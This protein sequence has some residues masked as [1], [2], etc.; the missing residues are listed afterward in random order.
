[1][2]RYRRRRWLW[3]AAI[4]LVVV[5]GVAAGGYLWIT[6]DP[7]EPVDVDDVVA[8][9]RASTTAAS[10]PAPVTAR[11]T[12]MASAPATTASAPAPTDVSTRPTSSAPVERSDP[13]PGVYV[14]DTTG[15]ESVDALGGSAHEYPAETTITLRQQGGEGCVRARWEALRQRWDEELRCP[16]PDG[17]SLDAKT[18]YH[19]FFRQSEKR[20]F[21]CEPDEVYLPADPAPELALSARCT[22]AGGAK[23]GRSTEGWRGRTVGMETLKIDGRTVDTFHVR[24]QVAIGGESTG[25][26][27]IDR[28]YSL[29]APTL[30]VR[31][32]RTGRT[33]SETVIGAVHYEERY[34]LLLRSLEPIA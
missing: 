15:R 32:L 33:T 17:W 27:D 26:A 8:D 30:L 16:H 19:S 28:W 3:A 34:E 12:T 10:A 13:T 11:P 9:Y 5:A 21:D 29:E 31:E 24:Y 14:Y 4:G 20:S 18:V 7:A 23:S 1:M 25:R 6:S 2:N 22:S